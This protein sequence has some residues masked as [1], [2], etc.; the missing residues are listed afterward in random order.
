MIFNLMKPQMNT[1]DQEE[2]EQALALLNILSLGNK[3][4]EQG[5]FRDS[6]DVFAELNKRIAVD[7][8]APHDTVAWK[9]IEKKVLARWTR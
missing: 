1:K 9:T 4:I 7:D 3:E 8:S 6:E 2:H 5:K